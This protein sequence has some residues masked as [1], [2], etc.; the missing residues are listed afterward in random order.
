MIR[1]DSNKKNSFQSGDLILNILFFISIGLMIW[2]LLVY[3][4]TIIESSFLI[5]TISIGII[6]GFSVLPYF[7]RSS[8]SKFW[9]FI[10]TAFISGGF[11]YFAILFTNHQFADKG[12]KKEQFLILVKG[13]LARGAK[14]NCNKPYV[15]IDFYGIKK[16][17]IFYCQYAETVNHSKK[18]NLT[19][20]KG[21]LGFYIIKS[22]QLI[23]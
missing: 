4:Q 5:V 3:R 19:Y 12:I 14:G 22:K 17:L 7:I 2:G 9:L 15:T 10:Y 1:K 8:F 23:Y 20:S 16:Q 13:T 18:I 6:I 11:F 21:A